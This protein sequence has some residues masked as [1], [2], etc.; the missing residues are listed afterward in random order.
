LIMG[1]WSEFRCRVLR[2]HRWVVVA[3]TRECWWCGEEE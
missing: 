3:G 1:W 2:W